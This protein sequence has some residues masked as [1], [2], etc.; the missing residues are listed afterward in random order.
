MQDVTT[1]SLA[2]IDRAIAEQ[3]LLNGDPSLTVNTHA[4]P[5]YD[6]EPQKVSFD[7]SSVTSGLDSFFLQ[8]IIYNI[9]KAVDDSFYLDL[10]RTLPNGTEEFL[11]HKFI[12]APYFV[13]TVR[14]SI[15]TEPTVAFGLNHFD[16]TVDAGNIASAS[17]DIDEASEMNNEITTSLLITSDDII[18]V[19]PYEFS[20]VNQPGVTLKAIHSESVCYRENNMSC[21]LTL[22][23][24]STAR[25]FSRKKFYR[26]EA[27]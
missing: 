3:M 24:I 18:P 23:R 15:K 20:I 27:F 5:D 26:Q 22:R 21:R 10:K 7:P 12:R 2:D 17:G 25:F 8:V 1:Q 11:Y 4:K 6:L 16:I 19:F 13:D 9:G 14:L